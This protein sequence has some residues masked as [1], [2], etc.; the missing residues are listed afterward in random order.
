MEVQSTDGTPN[1]N[2][3]IL[4]VGG[5]VGSAVVCCIIGLFIAVLV[6][7]IERNCRR[8]PKNKESKIELTK[9]KK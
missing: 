8:K 5:G 2:K 4:I 1:N 6:T 7:I 3:T 9:I